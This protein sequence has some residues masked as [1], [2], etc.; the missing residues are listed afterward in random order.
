MS[1]GTDQLDPVASLQRQCDASPFIRFAAI[2]VLSVDMKAQTA[3]FAMPFRPEF[4]RGQGTGQFHGGPIASLIDT[5]GCMALIAV[6]GR[7]A[8]TVDFRTD[9][10]RPAAGELQA[11]ARVR[12]AGRTMGVV[13]VDVTDAAGRLLATGRGTFFLE[14]TA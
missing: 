1:S 4:E 13:D 8:G 10:L 6:A 12:R 2:R 7:G 11:Q 9:Y 14:A 5:A 3:R